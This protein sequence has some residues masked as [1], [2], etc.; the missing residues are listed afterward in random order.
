M[1][2]SKRLGV[3]G[4]N[5]NWR[6]IAPLQT[7]KCMIFSLYSFDIWSFLLAHL[8]ILIFQHL[9]HIM[10]LKQSDHSHRAVKKNSNRD[11]TFHHISLQHMHLFL[12]PTKILQKEL[13]WGCP[14]Y[15]KRGVHSRHSVIDKVPLKKPVSELTTQKNNFTVS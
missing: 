4:G 7:P 15:S 6:H 1:R 14:R 5:P 11:T 12:L 13:E 10:Q 8:L 2:S 9:F 3:G